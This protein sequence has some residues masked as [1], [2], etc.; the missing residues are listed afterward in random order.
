MNIINI[1][2]FKI[3]HRINYNDFNYRHFFIDFIDY[4]GLIK[5]NYHQFE[6]QLQSTNI[7]QLFVVNL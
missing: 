2:Y 4:P 7:L 5:T 6:L 3:N 1:C